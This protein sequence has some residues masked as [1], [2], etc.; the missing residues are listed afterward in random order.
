MPHVLCLCWSSPRR[1]FCRSA[2]G[3]FLGGGR[4]AS[5]RSCHC[6][7]LRPRRSSSPSRR[8]QRCTPLA[9][10]RGPPCSS[11][12]GVPQPAPR[13][14]VA[15]WLPP[16]RLQPRGVATA[17]WEP[18]A[19]PHCGRHWITLTSRTPLDPSTEI[20][21]A[22]SP[23]IDTC[24]GDGLPRLVLSFDG[25]ARA[26]A[27]GDARVAG[28]GAVLWS[29][30]PRDLSLTLRAEAWVALPGEAWAPIAEA[31]G[32]HLALQLLL[33]AGEACLPCQVVGDNLAVMRFAAAQGSLRNPAH[34]GILSPSLAQLALRGI[35]PSWLAVRRRFNKAADSRA[36]AAVQWAAVLAAEGTL[37]PVARSV[38]YW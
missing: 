25:G 38:W 37:T 24:P 36:T 8:L 23:F 2:P 11:L 31:W 26:T 1:R 18:E 6:L 13:G 27:S 5:A 17:S 28:A 14:P 20:S 19:C 15:P 12:A 9:T 30:S 35:E 21:V 4:T 22:A 10:S 7:A 34:E 3:F 29:L 33:R 32:L 16:P